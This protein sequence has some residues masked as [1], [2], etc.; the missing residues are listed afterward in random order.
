MMA[1]RHRAPVQAVFDPVELLAAAWAALSP[2]GAAA[3]ANPELAPVLDLFRPA[4]DHP[5]LRLLARLRETLSRDQV[6]KALVHALTGSPQATPHGQMLARA[7]GELEARLGPEWARLTGPGRALAAERL[8]PLAEGLAP[9]EEVSRLCREPVPVTFHFYPSLFLPLPMDGRHGAAVPGEGGTEVFMFFGFPLTREPEEYGITRLWLQRGGW[10]YAA[11]EYFGRV[12]TAV[13]DAL[14]EPPRTAGRLLAAL[15]PFAGGSLQGVFLHH[16]NLGLRYGLF[17]QQ[18]VGRATFA[19]LATALGFPLIS[20]FQEE[21]DR[22][23]HGPW[24]EGVP[25]RAVIPGMAAR[26]RDDLPRLTGLAEAPGP[27]MPDLISCALLPLWAQGM[28]VVV[29]DPWRRRTDRYE[30][31]ARAWGR[32]RVE[33]VTRSE[34]EAHPDWHPSPAILCG[35]PA[36]QEEIGQILE[37]LGIRVTG[38]GVAMDGFAGEGRDLTLVALDGPRAD[39]RSW[40]MVVTGPDG[41][42]L[43]VPD[44]GRMMVLGCSRAVFRGDQVI[45]RQVEERLHAEFANLVITP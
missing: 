41:D 35:H 8:R 20:W 1:T 22:Y 29:P 43:Y 12:G 14:A 6:I 2:D 13:A 21:M 7:L 42:S 24:L 15:P 36:Q 45:H 9:A 23:L 28:R 37:R 26:F 27:Q 18:G 16:L 34:W 33:V 38:S 10:H 19:L 32:Y 4:A 3:L 17:L 25:L 40:R 11:R 39:D 31:L 5:A 44:Y 30:K